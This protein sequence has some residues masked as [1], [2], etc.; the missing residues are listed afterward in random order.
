MIGARR[1]A[2]NISMLATLIELQRLKRLD[3]TGWTLRGLANG[4]ES[5]AAHSFGV[6]ITAMLLADEIQARGTAL[7]VEKILR[8]ALLHDWAETRVG[9]MPKTA[10]SYF[11]SEARRKAE[12]A[13]FADVTKE[14]GAGRGR[15]RNLYDEYEARESLESLIVKAADVIDLLVQA[16]ALERGGA[17]GLDEFWEI[18][19]SDNLPIEGLPREV[20][21]ELI[22]ELIEA[23]RTLPR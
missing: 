6:G 14:A 10:V 19:A 2:V 8:M 15:Y 3:R 4:T 20:L 7:D 23:R 1:L 22:S 13:A 5:V 18:A 21:D 17:R 9:D 16:L 12:I 11:G